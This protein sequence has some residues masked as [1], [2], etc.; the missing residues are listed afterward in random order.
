MNS[1]SPGPAGIGPHHLGGAGRMNPLTT[2]RAGKSARRLPT[3]GPPGLEIS[4]SYLA[5]ADPFPSALAELELVEP[6]VLRPRITRQ[7]ER[8]YI[9]PAGPHPV[10]RDRAQE[11]ADELG[12]REDFLAPRGTAATGQ[13]A[14]STRPAPATY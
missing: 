11:L 10:T 1:E 12:T 5:P 14:A 7:L 9:D 2:A 8:E 4:S 3:P 13:K 6:H